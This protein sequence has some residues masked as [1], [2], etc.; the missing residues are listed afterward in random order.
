MKKKLLIFL[1]III[2]LD[3]VALG[4]IFFTRNIE[5]APVSAPA[6]EVTVAEAETATPT[7]Q[8]EIFSRVSFVAVGDNLVHDTI[9]NQ[10]KARSATGG[11]DFTDAY[12]R[13]AHLIEEPDVAILNQET[14]ISPEHNPANFP[15]FNSPVEVG[16]EMLE[17]GFDVFNIATN[18]SIDKGEKG[19]IAHINFWKEK[20]AITTGAYLNQEDY[21]NIPIHEVNGVRI[22]YIGLTDNTNGLNLPSD[23]EVILVHASEESRIQQRLA[24]AKELADVV[25]VNAHWGV[26]YS[27]EPS[28]A[29]RELA[30]KMASWGADVIIG[31]HP[32]VIQPVEYIE[33]A[34]G[35]RTLVAYSLGNFI[36]AQEKTAT[37][38]GGRLNFEIVKN[39]MTGGIAIEN[40]T[41]SGIVTHYSHRKTNLRAYPL[42]DYTEELASK[43]GVHSYTSSFSLERLHE[44]IDEVID[45]Q[46]LK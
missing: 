7:T 9:Y 26:E 29:Q 30:E 17:I 2:V 42:E 6:P 36:S 19:L 32:H 22:A 14:V 1:A 12:E 38:L 44:I 10:A 18:H 41:F 5:R 8:Q 27:H 25:I 31:H 16:E 21:A 15:R 3:I 33:N 37:M 28:Q 46:F 11:Y 24:A 13:V 40:V 34:D 23:S 4:V 43:H 35:R 39:N 20:G 45:K